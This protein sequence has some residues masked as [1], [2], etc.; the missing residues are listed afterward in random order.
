MYEQ[1]RKHAADAIA[2][3]HRQG[4][5]KLLAEIKLRSDLYAKD[6]PFLSDAPTISDIP[7]YFVR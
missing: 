3:A 1:A 5:A 7:K 2:A 4:N 6:Q